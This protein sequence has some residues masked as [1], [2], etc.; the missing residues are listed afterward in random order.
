MSG[1]SHRLPLAHCRQTSRVWDILQDARPYSLHCENWGFPSP[2]INPQHW[3]IG[4]GCQCRDM[5]LSR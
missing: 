4:W 2:G 1:Q 3:G 5:A